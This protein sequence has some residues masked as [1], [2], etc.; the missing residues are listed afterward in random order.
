[1]DHLSK[2]GGAN[3]GPAWRTHYNAGIVD[4]DV[5]PAESSFAGREELLYG[6]DLTDVCRDGKCF[7]AVPF[8]QVNRLCR[9]VD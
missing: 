5:D 4:H 3:I 2:P 7:S 6:V 9:A 1:L 8:D